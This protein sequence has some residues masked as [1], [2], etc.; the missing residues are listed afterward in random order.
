MLGLRGSSSARLAGAGTDPTRSP[1]SASGMLVD[2]GAPDCF[3]AAGLSGVK[4]RFSFLPI[5]FSSA[6][7]GMGFAPGG[8]SSARTASLLDG[9]AI[10]A[11]DVLRLSRALARLS[12]RAP[13]PLSCSINIFRSPCSPDRRAAMACFVSSRNAGGVSC[14][15]WKANEDQYALTG[16]FA[17]KYAPIIPPKTTTNNHGRARRSGACL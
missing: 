16:L 12:K 7:K 3:A 6:T 9:S 1:D 2:A 8:V 17:Q 15:A 4:V 10:S 5:G 13:S 14:F 11:R